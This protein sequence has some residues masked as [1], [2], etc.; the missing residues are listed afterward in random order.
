MSLFAGGPPVL[1]GL[2]DGRNYCSCQFSTGGRSFQTRVCHSSSHTAQ[3]IRSIVP[4]VSGGTTAASWANGLLEREG[5]VLLSGP[6]T[7]DSQ[8]VLAELGTGRSCSRILPLPASVHPPSP[9]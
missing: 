4:G 6:L 5:V 3:N 9:M 2:L 7:A 8:E 1:R